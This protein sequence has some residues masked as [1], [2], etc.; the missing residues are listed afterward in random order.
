MAS[1]GNQAGQGAGL[2]ISSASLPS[3][4]ISTVCRV[5]EP[6]CCLPVCMEWSPQ[7]QQGLLPWQT[8]H[9]DLSFTP[10]SRAAS[11]RG[12]AALWMLTMNMS[13]VLKAAVVVNVIP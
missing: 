2:P 3:G 11:S 1:R 4:S 7:G 10:G 5:R 8:E 9:R 13:G 12:A 6:A